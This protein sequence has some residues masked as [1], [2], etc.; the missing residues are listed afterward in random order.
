MKSCIPNRISV[1][2]QKKH[3]FGTYV[4]LFFGS[5]KQIIFR[6]VSYAAV[7]SV[8]IQGEEERCV[9]TLRVAA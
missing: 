9:T 1:D 8:V 3:L 7:L 2:Q 6:L 4:K 5:M